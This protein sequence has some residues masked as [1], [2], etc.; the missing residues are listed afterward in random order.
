MSKLGW[1]VGIIIV[2]IGM[3]IPY[4]VVGFELIIIGL[5]V[6]VATKLS[7]KIDDVRSD[8]YLL[9]QMVEKK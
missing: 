9:S 8:I 7:D 5:I 6:I 1:I 3:F 2:V 4:T